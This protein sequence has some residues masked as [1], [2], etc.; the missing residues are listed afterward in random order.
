MD[1]LELE[2][3][4]ASEYEN[5]MVDGIDP[6]T[7]HHRLIY[8]TPLSF[9]YR[10]WYSGIVQDRPWRTGRITSLD[11]SQPVECLA[12]HPTMRMAIEWLKNLD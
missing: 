8:A 4:I 9:Q 7:N 6:A 3:D 11:D 2:L 12:G 10:I 5:V 1:H